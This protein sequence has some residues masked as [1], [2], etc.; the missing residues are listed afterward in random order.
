MN[1]CNDHKLFLT[2]WDGALSEVQMLDPPEQNFNS[3]KQFIGFA[4]DL[5]RDLGFSI[6]PKVHEMRDHVVIR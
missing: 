5:I 4:V 6:T 3:A 2:L 1:I